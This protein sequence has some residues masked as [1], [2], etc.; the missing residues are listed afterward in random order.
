[1]HYSTRVVKTALATALAHASLR[2][3]FALAHYSRLPRQSREPQAALAARLAPHLLAMTHQWR[4][5]RSLTALDH[6]TWRELAAT[7]EPMCAPPLPWTWTQPWPDLATLDPVARLAA[8]GGVIPVRRG[9]HVTLYLPHEWRSVVACT[10]QPP[11]ER[12]LQPSATVTSTLAGLITTAHDHPT[13]P[14]AT[15][16]HTRLWQHVLRVTGWHDGKRFTTAG[17][18]WLAATPHRQRRMILDALTT[19]PCLPDLATWHPPDWAQVLTALQAHSHCEPDHT[20]AVDHAFALLHDH[21]A[22]HSVPAS[23]RPTLFRRWLRD[24]LHPAGLIGYDGVWLRWLGWPALPPP[25]LPTWHGRTITL[26]PT[27]PLA[28]HHHIRSW[29]VP[30]DPT[31]WQITPESIRAGLACTG[32]VQPLLRTCAQWQIAVPAAVRELVLAVAAG[33]AARLR[34][35][36]V[37]HVRDR[38]TLDALYARPRSAR[39]LGRRL[40]A[41]SA[42]VAPADVAALRRQLVQKGLSAP[43]PSDAPASADACAA[44]TP[45]L[46]L[47]VTAHQLPLMAAACHAA[48]SPLYHA[49]APALQ[50]EVDEQWEH[51]HPTLAPNDADSVLPDGVAP[52]AAAPY[53]AV[54]RVIVA[55]LGTN[56]RLRMRYYAASTHATTTRTIRPLAYDGEYVRAWCEHAVAERTFRLDRIIAIE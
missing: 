43:T 50:A 12:R 49:L 17:G 31:T 6:T 25:T 37:L 13:D 42:R 30:L 54:Q 28:L 46:A 56:T 24:T 44:I 23:Q 51:L 35:E 14:A 16:R 19:R 41:T 21:P 9:R 5:R 20:L 32:S 55:A 11:S 53:R 1:M 26:P 52:P 29:C 10:T 15:V 47:R 7:T 3:L 4:I 33:P 34:D 38:A 22:W 2:T 48:A 8:L 27:A 18:L 40:G 39:Q 45:I 36:T